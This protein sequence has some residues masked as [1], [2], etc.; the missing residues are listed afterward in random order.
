MTIV[1][2]KPDPTRRD[3]LIFAALW[4]VFFAFLS[5]VA[6]HPAPAIGVAAL[7][8]GA[9]LLASL[10]LN[11]DFPR[12]SQALGVLF[13]VLFGLI[14][15]I[16]PLAEALGLD[17]PTA[18]R[19]LMGL[20]LVGAGAGPLVCIV[21]RRTGADLYRAWML[22]A[23]P[24]GWGISHAFMLAVFGLVVTPLGLILRLVRY[25]PMQR[26]I[27]PEAESYWTPRKPPP[28]AKR[29]LRQS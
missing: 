20:L 10:L 12:R 19:V 23:M 25:D 24:L 17:A 2:I 6:L 21:S 16:G 5:R 22:A 14:W 27:E 18:R 7:V 26:R 1:Q 4:A 9:A 15:G 13:P 11:R 28:D 29:Y 3:V 8:A